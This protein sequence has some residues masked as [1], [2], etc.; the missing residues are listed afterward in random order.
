MGAGGVIGG[1]GMDSSRRI[2]KGFSASGMGSSNKIDSSNGID[3]WMGDSL[4]GMGE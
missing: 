4:V 2:E 1:V 3:E